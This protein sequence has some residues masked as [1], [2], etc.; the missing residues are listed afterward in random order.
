MKKNAAKGLAIVCGLLVM[1]ACQGNYDN[2][3]IPQGSLDPLVL[4]IPSDNGATPAPSITSPNLT[5]PTS[6]TTTLTVE[7]GLYPGTFYN[8]ANLKMPGIKNPN[9][10]DWLILHGT[11]R[12]D[13]NV[14]VT[15]DGKPKGFTVYNSMCDEL[16]DPTPVD[17]VFLVDNSTSMGDK[18][19][20]V[21]N[22]IKD[23]ANS[24]STSLDIKYAC[25]GYGFS[26]RVTGGI[27]FTDA[28]SL[29]SFLNRSTSYSRTIGFVPSG[30][31]LQ[32][33]AADPAYI[34]SSSMD[35]CGMLAA[36]FAHDNLSWRTNS[37]RVYIN[38][39]DDCND[40]CGNAAY[41]VEWLPTNWTSGDGEIHSVYFAISSYSSGLMST[42]WDGVNNSAKINHIEDPSLMAQ[43]TG[44]TSAI[45]TNINDFRL[46]DI[47]V[48][49][50]LQEYYIFR[51]TDIEEYV[52]DGIAHQVVI[53]IYDDNG[54][55]RGEEVYN[56]K[57]E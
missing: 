54:N 35:E 39:T 28:T 50:T 11:Y 53:T 43:Y 37:R 32:T 7:G 27:D 55:I 56:V 40:P 6:V 41:S 30:G 10:G 49:A 22:E 13:Q 36:R 21:A 19:D 4:S 25:I 38:L 16:T 23:W 26:G 24:L 3:I 5:L 44:G 52:N 9:T 57:F 15:V 31:D 51:F 8:V 47:P 48:T 29:E 2:P 20:K 14:W 33:K 17:I 12:T 34:I 1:T 46:R 42:W 45:Y 18:A